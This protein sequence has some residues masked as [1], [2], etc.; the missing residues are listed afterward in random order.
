MKEKT[1]I[2]FLAANSSDEIHGRLVKE[3]REIGDRLGVGTERDSFEL[4]TEW[5]VRPADIQR[6]LL[7][8]KPHIIHLAA[9]GTEAGD[10]L[11]A[12]DADPARSVSSAALAELF[13]ILSD[14]IRVVILSA[15]YADRLAAQLTRIIDYAVSI[16]SMVDGETVVT[17]STHFYQALGYGRTVVESFELARNQLMIDNK[18]DHVKF[19]LSVGDAADESL[20]PGRSI[21]GARPSDNAMNKADAAPT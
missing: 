2:L 7:A 6:H 4:I 11:M 20:S 14:N 13:R 9:R 17:F 10:I 18:P 3:A 5:A 8:H 12:D 21:S 16:N 1:K 15:D 19:V